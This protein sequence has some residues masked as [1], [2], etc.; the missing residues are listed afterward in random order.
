M[1]TTHIPEIREGEETLDFAP[2]QDASVTFI[3]RI[4]S[5]WGPGNCPRNIAGAR[6]DGRGA[7][8]ELA[9]G[10]VRGLGG[11]AVGQ[12]LLVLYW[13]NHARRDLIVQ[14]PGHVSA[15]RGTFALRS[16][17]RPNPITLSAVTITAIDAA[18]GRVEI[19]AIDCFDGTPVVDLKPWLPGIDIPAGAAIP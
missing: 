18:A 8:I 15:P 12:G 10:Y 1:D 4:R 11:L 14:A 13:M 16:P 17:N 19:D 6:E 3:G 5:P 7:T 9:P 2:A